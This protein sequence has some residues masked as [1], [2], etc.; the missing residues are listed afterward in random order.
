M[1]LD[2]YLFEEK[3]VHQDSVDKYIS[4]NMVNP[5]LV[6]ENGSISKESIHE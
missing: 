1:T 3:T 6:V 4:T 5:L 2:K